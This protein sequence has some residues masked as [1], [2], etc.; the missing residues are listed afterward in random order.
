MRVCV[1]RRFV[2]EPDAMFLMQLAALACTT[3]ATRLSSISIN[4]LSA[5]A[6]ATIFLRSF[7]PFGSLET[8]QNVIKQPTYSND[9]VDRHDGFALVLLDLVMVELEPP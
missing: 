4:G 7:A 2:T 8:K 9:V 3:V 5:P 1:D 6:A